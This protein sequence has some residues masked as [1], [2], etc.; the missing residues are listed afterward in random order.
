[1]ETLLKDIPCTS[2]SLFGRYP[3][4]YSDTEAEHLEAIEL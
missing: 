3:D 1:M 2:H 4:H